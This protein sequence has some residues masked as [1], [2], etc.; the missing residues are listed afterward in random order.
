[1][2][3]EKLLE[4]KADEILN[5]AQDILEHS[6]IPHYDNVGKKSYGVYLKNLYDL[7]LSCIKSKSL[8]AINEYAEILAKDR[9]EAG[10]DLHEVQ[11]VFNILEET[12]WMTIIHDLSPDEYEEALRLTSTILG[13]GKA[14]LADTYVSLASERKVPHRDIEALFKGTD[15]V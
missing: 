2:N 11:R 12:I 7:T 6:H 4:A 9:Y 3:L 5:Q 14:A 15:G 10:F 1:M 8:L 13:A